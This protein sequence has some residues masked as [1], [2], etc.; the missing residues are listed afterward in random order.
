MWFNRYTSVQNKWNEQWHDLLYCVTNGSAGAKLHPTPQSIFISQFHN[1]F[2]F[3]CVFTLVNQK[4]ERNSQK[5]ETCHNLLQIHVS[6]KDRTFYQLNATS[7]GKISV[8]VY[9]Y[10]ENWHNRLKSTAK[11]EIDAIIRSKDITWLKLLYLNQPIK[12]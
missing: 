7:M 1:F 2:L 4:F 9:K 5:R 12:A 11:I 3:W 10:T 8:A 6:S